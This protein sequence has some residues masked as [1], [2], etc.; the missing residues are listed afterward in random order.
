MTGCHESK[1]VLRFATLKMHIYK[2]FQ[3]LVLSCWATIDALK[4]ATGISDTH[5]I[6]EGFIDVA[7]V[8]D[9]EAI[10]DQHNIA[11]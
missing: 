7:S 3:A 4:S 8:Q 9:V 11:E 5:F 2:S 10:Q 6:K 1:I